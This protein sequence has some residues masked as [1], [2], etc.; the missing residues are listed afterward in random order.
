MNKPPSE[1]PKLRDGSELRV[2]IDGR[3]FLGEALEQLVGKKCP[4][5]LPRYN[6]LE[7]NGSDDVAK[8]QDWCAANARPL[9][10][11]GLSM[12]EAAELI[13]AQALENS[14]IADERKSDGTK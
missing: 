14:N 13:V 5:K 3:C 10:A 7:M 9:W 11:T 2:S 6:F 12:M 1:L 4:H 8:I